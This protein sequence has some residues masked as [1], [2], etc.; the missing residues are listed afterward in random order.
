MSEQNKLKTVL[1]TLFLLS[2]GFIFTQNTTGSP[3]IAEFD[4]GSITLAQLEVRITMLPPIYQP[5]YSTPEGKKDLLNDMCTEE[6]FYLEALAHNVKS[7]PRYFNQI[8]NQIKS[9]YY[10]EFRKDIFAKEIQYTEAEKKAYFNENSQLFPGR[11]YSESETDIERRL[12][13]AKEQELINLYKQ[14]FSEK[15]AVSFNDEAIMNF[16]IAFPD[17]HLQDNEIILVNSSD[18]DIKI[19]AAELANSW[20]EIPEQNRTALTT[21]ENLKKYLENKTD[22]ELF[23]KE[24]V[25]AGLEKNEYVQSTIE[26]IHRNMMLRTIYNQLVVDPINLDSK[27]LRNY[28][29]ANIS[30]FSSNPYRKIRTFGF[31]NEETAKQMLKQVK[32]LIKQGNEAELIALIQ[33]ESEYK[34]KDGI[35]NNIYQNEI[36]PGIGK[37][38][39]YSD[40]VWKTK[41]GKLSKIFK[42]S[43]DIWTFV[44]V[45]EDVQAV[46]TPFEELESKIKQQ[47]LK[48]ESRQKYEELS[49]SLAKK[50]NLITYPERMIVILSVE[51]YFNRAET[52]QKRRRFTD[53][54]FYYDQV[55][56]N[57]QNNVDDYKALFMKGF[58][59]AEE[60]NEPEKA[61]ECFVAIINDFP[62]SD[63]HESAQY[64]I[65]ELDGK[66]KDIFPTESE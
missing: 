27:S 51:D 13:P 63:L 9:V 29:K 41:P 28:Y 3:V 57:Y 6:L 61:R 15:Y 42:N 54:L 18:E 56:E 4:G 26:Q 65:D 17:S 64:M 43:K 58:L 62:P 36:I 38:K 40:H 24:A 2:A 31:P 10:G 14:K 66:H 19:T 37:D 50:Y 33:E 32:K 12:R 46:A 8:D 59:Y 55:I 52:A 49:E 25:A 48:D 5:K 22:L 45:L 44:H 16:N 35:I 20:S 53:A 39:V 1:A 30:Q 7:D 21:N 11:T 60:L 34:A 23:F 47:K